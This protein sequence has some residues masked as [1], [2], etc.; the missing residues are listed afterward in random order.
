MLKLWGVLSPP[1]ARVS[2]DAAAVPVPSLVTVA[3]NV[4]AS[5]VVG[6]SGEWVRLVTTRSG[7]APVT[8]KVSVVTLFVS[9]DSATSPLASAVAVFMYAW[10]TSRVSVRVT[11]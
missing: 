5:S 9:S 8:V 1:T 3:V 4:M 6:F 2:T 7:L 10:A 11:V